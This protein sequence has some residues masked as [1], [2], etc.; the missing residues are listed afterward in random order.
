MKKILLLLLLPVLVYSQSFTAEVDK[1]TVGQNERFRVYFKI[2]GENSNA[3]KNFA[4]P[5]FDGFSV[6][7]GP[8][9]STSMQII[10]GAVSSSITFSYILQAVELGKF[11]IGSASVEYAGKKMI[12]KPVNME[13]VK[14][15]P[16]AQPDQPGGI[17]NEE[18]AKNVF[19]RAIPNKRNVVR[20]EQVIVSYK[21]Y[22]KLNI[23]NP[24]LSKLP[25]YPGFWSEELDMPNNIGYET[26]MYNGERFKTVEFKKVALFPTQTGEL[27]VTPI[28]LTIPVVVRKKNNSRD[29]FDQFFNNSFFGRT[30]TIEYEAVSN[31]VKI[32]V[33]Q[34]P[35][36]NA[37]ASFGGAV[38]SYDFTGSIDKRTVKANEDFT[39]RLKI[40]GT[41]NISLATLPEPQLPPGF[42]VYDP[43]KSESISREGT[44]SGNKTAEYLIV[45]RI[46]G[47]KEIPV[48]EFTYYDLNSDRF[49]TKTVGP[50][51]I[52]VE[53]GDDEFNAG[54]S[55]FSKEDVQLLSKDIRFIKT[56]TALIRANEVSLIPNWFW[57]SG[58]VPLVIL[59][60]FIG[61]NNRREK[62]SGDVKLMKFTKAE[63]IARGKLKAAKK[64]LNEQKLP[65]FYEEISKAL[66]GYLEDKL[67]LSKSE[68]TLDRALSELRN[69]KITEDEIGSVKEIADKCE[70]ARFAPSA[71]SSEAGD[72]FYSKTV[73]TIT[74]LENRL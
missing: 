30:E 19:V 15:S 62:L 22:T 49:V 54:N 1:T 69:R 14:G 46:Q 59:F 74:E 28:Q 17:S 57:V 66:Y 8:N 13:V 51:N 29:A 25:S 12:T 38:G 61:I 7:S 40:S 34:L 31:T 4:P 55:G 47:S 20:G 37:P 21:L 23:S 33:K 63:K 10:N 41:G 52:N 42:E 70:F 24:Q 71:V 60:V 45:P 53:K 5:S 44:V 35:L 16:Q 64:A 56:K 3:I 6:L 39:I 50:F 67:G 2:E 27:E 43:K 68:M 36:A 26:E 65:V 11:T 72:E 48:M 32:D 18:L 9:R 73:K 58:I